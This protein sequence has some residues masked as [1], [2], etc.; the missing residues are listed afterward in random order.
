MARS[1]ADLALTLVLL[2]GPDEQSEGAGY[3]LALPAPR[4]D[5]FSDYRVLVIGEYPRCPTTR[6]ITVAVEE[7]ADRLARL[8]CTVL[9]SAPGL[10]DLAHTMR[11]HV[12]LVSASFSADL[13][14]ER[15]ERILARAAALAPDDDSI[16]TLRARGLTMSHVDWIRASRNRVGLTSRW[17]A[18]FRDIDAILS[19]VMPTLAFA[20]DHGPIDERTLDIDGRLV[21]Y[22]DQIAWASMA[23]LNGLPATTLPIGRSAHGLPIAAQLIGGFL[24]DRTT[25]ALAGMIER[26]LGCAFTVPPGY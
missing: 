4:H 6:S 19:P 25:I 10:P 2:A 12:Q 26:E 16:T 20:H 9:R 5:R 18:L 15:R 8:G 11:L 24:E 1:A 23:I 22:E 21:P 17:R 3:R 13:P 14:P 7:L